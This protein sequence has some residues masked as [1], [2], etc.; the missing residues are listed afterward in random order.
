M[1]DQFI[2][3]WNDTIRDRP[4]RPNTKIGDYRILNVLGIGS[5]GIAYL[6]IHTQTENHVVLKQVK[7]SLRGTPK[8]EVMQAY[9]QKVLSSLSHPQIPKWLSS[10][11]YRKDSFL[12]MSYLEGPTLEELLFDHQIVVDEQISARLMRQIGELVAYLHNQG[13]IHRDV[14]IPNVIWQ[15]NTPFLIDFGLA[16]F[17]GDNPT[18][19]ADDLSVYSSEK[20]LKREVAPSS[21]LYALGH[22]FLFM[23]YSG[24]TA[25]EHEPERSWE[26]E[27]SLTPALHQM[28]RR[29]L[30]LDPRYDD[31][32][33]WLI[34]L[35][36]YLVRFDQ[37]KQEE[38]AEH[39][40]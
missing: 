36:S 31:V 23:L 35:D 10:F 29:L 38:R 8:G 6:A 22:F 7:P 13:L 40:Q 9:E 17:V 20:Q 16:R 30:Q 24:Y 4:Y 39:A 12:V 28:I 2:T 14:R 3:W 33:E 15:N 19:S 5:Y 18:Y 37:L 27:L 34:D 21:D 25:N 11:R 1:W 26:E 32:Q